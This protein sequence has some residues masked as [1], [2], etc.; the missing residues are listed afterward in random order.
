MTP[1]AEL[2]NALLPVDFY[3]HEDVLSIS[4]QLL[5]KF[6][7]TCIGDQLTGGMIIETEA[8]RAPED[9]ASHAYGLRRTKRNE[10]M[11]QA[12][13][14][15]YVYLCYGIHSLFNIVTNQAGIPHAILIRAIEPVDGI[16]IML[17]RRRKA[18]WDKTLAGGP[19]ALSQ[20]LGIALHHNGE[21][22][23][24]SL[25]WVE[26]RGMM[27][28]DDDILASPRV[29]IDYAGEDALLPWRF[30]IRKN[31]NSKDR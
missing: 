6:L 21:P 7:F 4:K 27:I 5:G 28:N 2:T 1:Q 12:G 26:D 18:Q 22:L 17:K 15:S 24:G 14:I 19:G 3:R 11:Y 8:Y 23:T 29:G 10:A 13:G 9:R 30:R 20:A 16:A 31:S 25:I